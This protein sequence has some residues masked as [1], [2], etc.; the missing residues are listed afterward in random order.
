LRKQTS[1]QGISKTKPQGN[2]N[3]CKQQALSILTLTL[4]GLNAPIKRH[5]I[6]NWVQKQDP[7]ICCLQETHLTEKKLASIKE[8]KKGFFK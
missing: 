8:S 3:N 7:T 6:A 5:R 4:N 1:K 2:K